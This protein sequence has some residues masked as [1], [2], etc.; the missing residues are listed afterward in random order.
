MDHTEP[1]KA[2]EEDELAESNKEHVA[3]RAPTEDEERSADES[4]ERYEDDA[5]SVAEHERSMNETGAN[6]KGEGRVP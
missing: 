3:D 4:R 5:E 2:T 1:D 6:E